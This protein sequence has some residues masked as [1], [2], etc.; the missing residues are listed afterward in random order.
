MKKLA[1]ASVS[2]KGVPDAVLHEILK[3]AT[4]KV[5]VSTS[6]LQ[7][8]ANK[9]LEKLEFGSVS[10]RWVPKFMLQ[11]DMSSRKHVIRQSLKLSVE[12]CG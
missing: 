6:V 1:F 4:G 9:E 3:A 11:R 10:W 5:F 12:E 2:A 7:P 8:L